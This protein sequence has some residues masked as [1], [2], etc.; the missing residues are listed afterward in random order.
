MSGQ[1]SRSIVQIL[2]RH[3][4]GSII[5]IDEYGGIIARVKG[6]RADQDVQVNR[7]RLHRRVVEKM[8]R[9]K[10]NGGYVVGMDPDTLEESDLVPL[11]PRQVEWEPFGRWYACS[12]SACGV[13]HA[14]T[15]ADFDG[16]CRECRGSLRQLPYIF[17][18]DCGSIAE[19]SP[20]TADACP[21]HGLR[22]LAFIDNHKLPTSFWQ[23][24]RCDHRQRGIYPYCGN[25]HCRA[26][27]KERPRYQIAHWR[28]QWAY[29]PQTVDYVNLD[30]QRAQACVRSDRGKQ[31]VHAAVV[32]SLQAGG[33]RLAAAL[34]T[35]DT[36]CPNCRASVSSSTKFCSN[37]GSPMPQ[38][39]L[40]AGT[41]IPLGVDDGRTTFAVLRD[42]DQSRSLQHE[43]AAGG[44]VSSML[45]GQQPLLR[46]GVHDVVLVQDFPLTTALI[47]YTRARSDFLAWLRAFERRDERNIVYTHSVGTEAWLVQLGAKPI[48]SW[49][50]AN[51]VRGED[52]SF[53]DL[54]SSE[55]DL[56]RWLIA[57]IV[58][59]D[60]GIAGAVAPLLHSY[61]HAMLLGLA[62]A[63]G[64]E[65]S[66][67]GEMIMPDALAFAIYAGDSELGAL[68]AAFDQALNVVASNVLDQATCKFDPGCATDDH[69]ACVGCIQ[70]SR[71]CERFNDGLSRGYLFG[72]L[73]GSETLPES[74]RGYLG[75][76]ALRESLPSNVPE[77]SVSESSLQPAGSG[78]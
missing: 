71:G 18:H 78:R 34:Q 46:Q 6:F 5:Y 48:L 54:T 53:P 16:T 25:N 64:L 60:T 49:L 9:W 26:L 2:R 76:A 1:T 11:K 24:R 20:K 70:L 21:T 55:E 43:I 35:G 7:R 19:L 29:Y 44:A 17:Y 73:T 33:G 42:L 14:D 65:A 37:C 47:G 69:G 31:L 75:I 30:E 58:S 12:N 77:A 68:T 10:D 13:M 28:E 52:G 39:A 59:E 23:C 63:G 22:Y 56:K 41:E 40:G 74:S 62:V 32:G 4:P 45:D 57:R 67:L 61:A 38:G 27:K 66:S 72:G 36:E 3:G 15:D 51:G 50:D 8:R